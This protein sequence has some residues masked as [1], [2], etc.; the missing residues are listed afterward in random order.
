MRVGHLAQDAPQLGAA[1]HQGIQQI[2]A[3]ARHELVSFKACP[4]LLAGKD[5]GNT[6]DEDY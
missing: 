2:I 4:H 1:L 3:A 5:T 6:E